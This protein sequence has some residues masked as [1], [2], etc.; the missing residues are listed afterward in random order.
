MF[1]RRPDNTYGLSQNSLLQ[2]E[3]HVDILSTYVQ[4]WPPVEQARN[5]GSKLPTLQHLHIISSLNDQYYPH[6]T[7]LTEGQE[8]SEDLVLKRSH[9][10]SG[11]H[12]IFPG[13]DPEI[14]CWKHLNNQAHGEEFWMAQEYV[15]SLRNIGEWRS[16]VIGGRVLTTM[17]MH[18]VSN[19]E[20]E[21]N[22]LFSVVKS[23]R[24]LAEIA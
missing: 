4:L 14:R 3:R 19:G 8:I 16:I 7:R 5:T 9:S 10:N 6:T 18:V 21:N 23:F 1:C 20:N 12:V 2:Y 13:A 22:R 24:T 17:H 11:H 15:P